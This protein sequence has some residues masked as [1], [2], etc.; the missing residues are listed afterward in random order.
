[1]TH[2]P[3]TNVVSR[4]AMTPNNMRLRCVSWR[5]AQPLDVGFNRLAIRVPSA[6]ALFYKRRKRRRP[7]AIRCLKV[8]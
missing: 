1:M 7:G 5:T 8:R 4:T 2:R 6:P 3:S